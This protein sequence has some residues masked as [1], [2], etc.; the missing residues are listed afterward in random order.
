MIFGYMDDVAVEFAV[1]EVGNSNFLFGRFY[2]IVNNKRYFLNATNISINVV[3]NC[4]R[5]RVEAQPLTSKTQANADSLFLLGSLINGFPGRNSVPISPTPVD[6]SLIS[7]VNEFIENYD[8][9][10]DR[11]KSIFQEGNAINFGGELHA[12]GARC[13]LFERGQKELLVISENDGIDIDLH[14]LSKGA[15]DRFVD[16]LPTKLQ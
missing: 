11:I 3:L 15:Y 4:L 13:F 9:F 2:F 16:A 14:M 5:K 1:D 7:E 10:L 12:E 8:L 6:D